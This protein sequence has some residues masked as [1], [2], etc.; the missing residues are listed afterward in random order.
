LSEAAD[1]LDSLYPRFPAHVYACVR[2]SMMKRWE[3]LQAFLEKGFPDGVRVRLL[4]GLDRGGYDLVLEVV[5]GAGVLPTGA[6]LPVDCKCPKHGNAPEEDQRPGTCANES[7]LVPL[8]RPLQSPSG[9]LPWVNPLQ[10][11]S[12]LC[13]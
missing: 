6:R 4:H 12:S 10:S 9:M 11:H 3:T 5:D 8:A 2:V 1:F 13:V 7:T